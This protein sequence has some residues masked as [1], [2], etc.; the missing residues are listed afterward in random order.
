MLI[1]SPFITSIDTDHFLV[2]SGKLNFSDNEK[3]LSHDRQGSFLEQIDFTVSESGGTV[4]GSLEKEGGGDLT[5]FWSDDFDALDC[6]GPV[7][8]VDLTPRVGTDTAPAAAFVYILQSDKTTLVAATSF[9]ANSV[10]H[11]RVCSLVL[12]SA[13][14]TGTEG[15]LMIRNW[16]D[17]AFGITN[18]RGG[19]I[20]S[21]ERVRKE[22]ALHNSGVVLSITGSGTGTI[23]LDTTAGTVYQFNLQ[24]F[25]AIDMA[26]A[27]NIHLVNL[28]GSEYSTSVNL[29][30]DI[31]T[32]AD[33]V[34]AIGNNKYFNIVVWG[35][36][37][38]TGTTSHL[39]CNLP[40]GQY[41][42]SLGGTTDA[43]KFSVHTIPSAF[44]GTGF[45]IAE[46][47]FQLTGGGTTWTTVQ[48]KDLL[49]QTPIL[50]PGGGT[51]TAISMFPDSAFEIFD[52]G[53]DSKEGVFEL[54]GITTGNIRT[55]TWPDVSTKMWADDGS[56][57]LTANWNVGSFD[58]TM[59]NLILGANPSII[60]S[61][62][63]IQLKPSG[64]TDDYLEFSTNS[65]VPSIK[66]IGGSDLLLESDNVGIVELF[67]Q[68]SNIKN[69]Q[70]FW[71]KTNIVGG[72]LCT[73][74]LD[75]RASGDTDDYIQLTTVANVPIIGTVGN[76]DLK[77][78]SSSGEIDFDNENL[79]TLGTLDC[80]AATLGGNLIIPDAGYI[81]SVSHTNAIQIEADGDIV[82][83]QY[84]T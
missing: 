49:G 57:P 54:S 62:N 36:Q 73:H 12:Q 16:N 11:I 19:N 4:T 60:S 7:C 58:I 74:P 81:G 48:N 13:A 5:Q 64:D 78:T 63:A 20:V 71:D 59:D 68:E 84:L 80:G 69:I 28:S 83:D 47:T 40:T 52:N 18:P 51:T 30:A 23:T 44:R 66:I 26:G 77:I 79:T 2:T 27:D 56:V 37:N 17:P 35:V 61:A 32:L 25:P 76:C 55:L 3:V 50:V 67:V 72:L 21:S 22:H 65:D 82:I 45:L 70:L 46:L 43:Q 38:R 42:N 29:V 15:A 75:L 39:M 6:T 31:T 1:Q 24:T 53:D 9:P 41:N 10:E 33:G 34:T 14:T 8:T